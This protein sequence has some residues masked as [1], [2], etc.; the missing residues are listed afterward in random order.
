MEAVGRELAA[1]VRRPLLGVRVA[2]KEDTDV[3]GEPAASGCRGGFPAAVADA[4]ATRACPD[5]TL[6][7]W[8][9]RRWWA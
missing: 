6:C 8:A 1:G 4:P 9:M 2:V 5:R 3:A 7:P